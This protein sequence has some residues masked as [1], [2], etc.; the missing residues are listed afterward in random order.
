MGNSR[1]LLDIFVLYEP[2]KSAPDAPCLRRNARSVDSA[3]PIGSPLIDGRIE[4]QHWNA[5]RRE[6][7]RQRER[8]GASFGA[9]LVRPRSFPS[10]GLSSLLSHTIRIPPRSEARCTSSRN[11]E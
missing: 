6:N 11:P 5:V 9:T 8:I 1:G 2:A 4:R 10:P 7:G 3:R